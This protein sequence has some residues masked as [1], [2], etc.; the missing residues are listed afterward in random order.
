MSRKIKLSELKRFD[1]A[2][3]LD[4]EKAIAEYLS[5]VLEEND[6]ALLLAA[7]NDVARARG[8]TEVS[9]ASGVTREALYKALSPGAHPRFDTIQRVVSA[10]GVRFTVVPA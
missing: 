8:M 9:K 4:D 1:V 10:F 2:E 5:V 7:L 6:E 3:Y